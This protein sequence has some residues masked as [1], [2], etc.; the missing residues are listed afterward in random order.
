M[1]VVDLESISVEPTMRCVVQEGVVQV[2]TVVLLVSGTTPFVMYLVVAVTVE[3]AFTITLV[4]QAVTILHPHLIHVA[5][6]ATANQTH[7]THHSVET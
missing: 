7:P 6:D 2:S 5:A 4:V 3:E 1:V